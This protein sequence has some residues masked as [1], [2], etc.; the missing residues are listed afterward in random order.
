[1]AGSINFASSATSLTV[2]N[3][4]VDASSVIMLTIGSA[5]STY[6]GMSVIP[7]SGQFAITLDAS[8]GTE[9]KVFFLVIN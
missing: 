9:T 5:P 7:S 4:L 8:F 1:M 6:R 3:N 2:T